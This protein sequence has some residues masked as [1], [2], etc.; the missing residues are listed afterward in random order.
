MILVDPQGVLMTSL[1]KDGDDAESNVDND[2]E[3][4]VIETDYSEDDSS[5]G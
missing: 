1:P 4:H 3:V 5:E 2:V